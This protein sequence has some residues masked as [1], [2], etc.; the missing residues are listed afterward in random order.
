MQVVQIANNLVMMIKNLRIN[1]KVLVK[2]ILSVICIF[3]CSC[4]S[5]LESK[6]TALEEKPYQTVA[7]NSDRQTNVDNL[8]SKQTFV[9]K[10]PKQMDCR[11]LHFRYLILSNELWSEKLRH[12]DIFMEPSAFSEG[13][14]NKLFKIFSKTFTKPEVLTITVKTNWNQFHFSRAP[15]CPGVAFTSESATKAQRKVQKN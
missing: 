13:N 10:N 5:T 7:Y 3:T 8:C 11:P 15:N 6:R 1:Y 4:I 2:H 12:I 14:L 9:N